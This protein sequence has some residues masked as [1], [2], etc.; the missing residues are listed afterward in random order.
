[1]SI[2]WLVAG[3][4]VASSADSG[5][6]WAQSCWQ[7]GSCR[8]SKWILSKNTVNDYWPLS[9]AVIDLRPALLFVFIDAIVYLFGDIEYFIFSVWL[10]VYQDEAESLE[11]VLVWL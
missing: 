11:R 1:M 5:A 2:D 10:H 4:P 6:R 9:R 8:W 3:E 7:A